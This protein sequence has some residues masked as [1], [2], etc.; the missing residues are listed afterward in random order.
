M[1]R[2]PAASSRSSARVPDE[3]AISGEHALPQ[4]TPALP[5]R[6]FFERDARQVAIELLGMELHRRINGAHLAVRIVET[7]AYLGVADRAAHSFGGRCTPRN[8]A[9]WGP[10]GHAYIY[11]TYGMHHCLNVVTEPEGVPSAV[12]IRAGEPIEGIELMARLRKR[13]ADPAHELA[14][15]PAKL[16][17]ALA[18]DL[19]LNGTDLLTADE[20]W[21]ERPRQ[22]PRWTIRCGPRVGIDYAADWKR[23]LLRFAPAG[24][25]HVSRP[26]PDRPLRRSRPVDDGFGPA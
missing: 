24:H 18:L 1:P 16:C 20:L 15:G 11:F 25:P 8:R 4:G 10:P 23:R 26:P 14:S 22:A 13:G 9:M 21:L 2:N 3:A 19:G 6:P 17:Q 12:L 7:E 5:E